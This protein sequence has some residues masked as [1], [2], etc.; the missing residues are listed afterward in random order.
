[1]DVNLLEFLLNGDVWMMFSLRFI[2]LVFQQNS[3]IA[4]ITAKANPTSKTTKTPPMLTT[5]KALA[6]DFLSMLL[7]RR[8]HSPSTELGHRPWLFH[9]LS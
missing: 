7:L 4:T 1:M 2:V 8:A 3:P 9:H 6:I 5:P